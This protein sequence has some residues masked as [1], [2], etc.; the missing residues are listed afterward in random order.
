MVGVYAIDPSI[1]LSFIDDTASGN[2]GTCFGDFLGFLGEASLLLV[3]LSLRQVDRRMIAGKRGGVHGE[4]Y[5]P[6][7]RQVPA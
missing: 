2:G 4:Q 3:L 7:I 6:R 1:H 5:N